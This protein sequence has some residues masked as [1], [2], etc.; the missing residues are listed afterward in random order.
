MTAWKDLER[1]VMAALGTRRRGQVVQGGWA[2]GSDDDGT[3]P[4][5][6]EVKRTEK[7]QIRQKWI[8][9][10]KAQ[11]QEDGRPWLLVV[12]EHYD[13]RPLVICELTT[14]VYLLRAAGVIPD[15]SPLADT[16]GSPEPAGQDPPST[17]NVTYLR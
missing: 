1:R 2:R 6:I 9:Q 16:A 3:G 17:S 14:M 15:D 12:A 11:Q 5:N 10:V 13:R 7:Y 4:F 8:E